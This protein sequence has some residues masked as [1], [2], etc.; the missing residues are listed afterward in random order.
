MAPHNCI[1]RLKGYAYI[2]NSLYLVLEKG[3]VSLEER[4]QK[5]DMSNETIIKIIVCVCCGLIHMHQHNYVHRDIKPS[6]IVVSSNE[7]AKL[8]D[9][10]IS[11]PLSDEDMTIDLGTH[12]YIA[13]EVVSGQYDFRSDIYSFGVV[14][15]KMLSDVSVCD[16][17]D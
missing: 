16:F 11:R 12:G 2:S 4:I 14:I 5:R 15:L 13:P 6:N 17:V 3:G 9:F 1:I 8:I 10:G 7:E